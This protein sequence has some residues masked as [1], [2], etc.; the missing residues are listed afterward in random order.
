M[1]CPCCGHEMNLDSHRKIDL[2]MC[3]ECGYIEGRR[4]EAAPAR[5]ETNYERLNHMN[6]NETVA[7][8]SKGLGLDEQKL[9]SWMDG[10]IA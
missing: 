9:A 7:F 8:L 3:Y 10:R 4:L 6:L 5:R 1:K 2:F